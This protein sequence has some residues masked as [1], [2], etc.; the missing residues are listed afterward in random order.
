MTISGRCL[1]SLLLPESERVDQLPVL[2]EI[3]S[4]EVLQEA[5]TAPHH[6]EEPLTAMVIS[7]VLVEVGSQ[8]INSLREEGDLN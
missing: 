1:P 7:L 3:R 8:M 4:P 2:I 6:L 5:P